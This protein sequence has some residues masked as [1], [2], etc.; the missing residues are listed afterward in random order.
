M[1]GWTQIIS[2]RL[3]ELSD[4]ISHSDWYIVGFLFILII[5]MIGTIAMLMVMLVKPELKG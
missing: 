5:L 4:F 2:A 3:L 1:D